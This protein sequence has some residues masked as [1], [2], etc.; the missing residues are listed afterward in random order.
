MSIESTTV[1]YDTVIKDYLKNNNPVV[2]ILTPCYGSSCFVNYVTC[3][4][5][6]RQLFNV[7]NIPLH[8]NFCKNDS[9]ITRA[10][11]NLVAKA[12]NNPEMTHILFIDNDITWDPLDILKLII[13]DKELVGGIYPYK[14]YNW[15]KLKEPDVI[16]NIL[17][18][19]NNSFFKNTSDKE[20]IQHSLLEYNLNYKSKNIEVN[21]NL[22]EVRHIA[23]GFML[24]KRI[25]IEKLFEVYPNTKY[26]DDIN[27]LNQD[28]EKFAYA[29][30]DCAV[31][32]KH[33]FSEDWLFC[34]RWS[35]INGKIFTDISINL[36]HTGL[37][38]YN[39]SILSSL[40]K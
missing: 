10:R 18:K 2:H 5:A 23:T 8:I 28:E 35:Q 27:Y 36:Q 32:D 3:I 20:I 39:G 15:D 19:K 16:Q 12:M 22:I 24:I 14:N 17:N 26:V 1:S 37:E 38:D 33:Y 25:V 7:Y 11:N 9:L 13:S 21:N 31:I 6:T 29:L 4:M 30:F 34:H 40:I